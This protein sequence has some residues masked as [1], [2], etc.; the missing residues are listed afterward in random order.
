MRCVC[1]NRNLNDWESTLK[2]AT[3]GQY[4][5]MCR[6]CLNGLG[7][8]VIESSF[9]TNEEA[10]EDDAYYGFDDVELRE[11][12]EDQFTDESSR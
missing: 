5:D 10:P 3:T 7:I 4:L 6:K 1:C 2:S 11:F 9:Q 8:P 12:T